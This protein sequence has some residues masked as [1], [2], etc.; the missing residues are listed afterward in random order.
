VEQDAKKQ[1]ITAGE[2]QKTIERAQQ[3]A[4]DSGVGKS[5]FK[6]AKYGPN[7]LRA[8]IGRQRTC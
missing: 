8:T 6:D 2:A 5:V 4:K 1:G 7:S 3:W